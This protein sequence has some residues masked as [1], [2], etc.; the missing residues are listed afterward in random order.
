MQKQ[1][2]W[3]LNVNIT[4]LPRKSSH[5]CKTKENIVLKEKSL[6]GNLLH[7]SSLTFSIASMYL[8]LQLNTHLVLNCN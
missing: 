1:K 7:N 6:N 8:Y 5:L 4:R 2:Y 3:A